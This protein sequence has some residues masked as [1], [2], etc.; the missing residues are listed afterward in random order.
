VHRWLIGRRLRSGWW[1]LLP[2]SLL[3]AL[4]SLATFVAI[5]TAQRTRDAY[6]D[7]LR[8]AAVGDLVINPSLVTADI[9]RVIRDLPGVRQV[10]TDGLFLAS[11]GP[12]EGADQFTQ[13]RGS[14]DGRF[15]DM[16]RPAVAQGRLPTGRSEAFVSRDLARRHHLEIGDVL[17]LSFYNP[18]DEL[19]PEPPEQPTSVGSEQVRIVGVGTFADQVLPDN[20]FPNE[21]VIVSQDIAR[22]YDCAAQPMPPAGTTAAAMLQTLLPDGCARS[23][24]Y[25]SLAVDGGD[26]GVAKA[27]AAFIAKATE[28]NQSLPEIPGAAHYVMIATT[29]AQDRSE[30]DRSIGPTT[31]ALLVLGLAAALTTLVLCGLAMARELRRRDEEL[32]AWWRFGLTR[33]ERTSIALAP[34]VLATM[35]GVSLALIGAWALSSLGPIGVV[36]S[37]ALSPAREV[38]SDVWAAAGALVVSL[39]GMAGIVTWRT[40]RRP[41]N[42]ARPANVSSRL[43]RLVRGS[44]RPAIGEGVRGAVGTRRAL[45]VVLSTG[46]ATTVLIGTLVFGASLSALLTHPSS[47]GWPW[48]VA[49]MSNAGYGPL[50]LSSAPAALDVRDIERW[51]AL[52]FTNNETLDGRPVVTVVDAGTS[53]GPAFS[54]VDGRL[55]VGPDEVAVGRR[56]AHAWKLRVGDRVRLGGDDVTS[57]EVTVTGVAV[58]P[59]LGRFQD[60]RASP[61]LGILLPKAALRDDTF[62]GLPSFIGVELAPGT[63]ARVAAAAV[64]DD[65]ASWQET[66]DA[67]LQF[68]GPAQPPEIVNARSVRLVPG[69]VT[70]LLAAATV[71]GLAI[72]VLV[73]VHA[74]RR[75]LATLSAL[76]FTGT[77]VR[78]S[79]GVQAVV[80]S[81]AAL[82]IGLP[83]GLVVGQW[84]WR[85]FAFELGVEGTPTTP[86]LLL[87]LVAA[88]A[89]VLT[90]LASV[91]GQLTATARR[92]ARPQ[93]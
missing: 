92:P 86:V 53:S 36:R 43:A 38:G 24:Q 60:D 33:A 30:V 68:I 56:T 83:L 88:G 73:S 35:V 27:E 55:P 63:D 93:D 65:V 3:V 9:D 10:T 46:I 31:S 89:V 19:E 41:A 59:P 90:W 45:L 52:G 14:P 87:A 42:A 77:Q 37:V 11:S 17:P 40:C 32:R 76:G 7:Y 69:L 84:A 29:T 4:G 50:D 47:Y 25:Y 49:V 13:L 64:R 26:A 80:T 22:K 18:R 48:D 5:G 85:A 20:L 16:D 6:P 23:Y 67:P 75:E 21:R 8:R 39:I 34:I 82:V 79:V 1:S 91:P 81:L 62:E 74:R 58:M 72:A 54:V 44:P 70:I 78:R 28:L 61:G 57:R 66:K 2:L 15:V 71:L 51:S 12:E